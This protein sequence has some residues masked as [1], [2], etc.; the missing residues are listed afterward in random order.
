MLAYSFLLVMRPTMM[1]LLKFFRISRVLKG[2]ADVKAEMSGRDA[3]SNIAKAL[4]EN[5]S[6]QVATLVLLSV[7]VPM[8]LASEVVDTTAL[9]YV[10]SLEAIALPQVLISSSTPPCP[11]SPQTTRTWWEPSSR[12]ASA[13]T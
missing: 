5:I 6:R 7:F 3:P 11:S 13:T 8:F 9:A 12:S 10:N 4:S 1:T 2:E